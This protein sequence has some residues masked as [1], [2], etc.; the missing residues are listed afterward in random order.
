MAAAIRVFL[1]LVALVISAASANQSTQ[2]PPSAPGSGQADQPPPP[3]QMDT[4]LTVGLWKS[5]FGP[6]KLE[7]DPEHVWSCV[8]DVLGEAA[9]QSKADPI[10]AMAI[11]AQGEAC[12]AVDKN[13]KCLTN[14]VVTFDARTADMP[15]W[16]EARIPM[17]SSWI[18]SPDVLI[19]S[20]S[21]PQ[22]RRRPSHRLPHDP[23]S[24]G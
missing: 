19:N 24:D 4:R 2:H 18:P 21:P 22:R 20:P 16:W 14:S 23:R 9:A 7:L 5:S 3:Q 13:G 10:E 1:L 12:H 11:S 15:A 8:R 17:D 6:V